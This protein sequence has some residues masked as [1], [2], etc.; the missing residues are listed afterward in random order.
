[1][2]TALG[3]V[4]F[5][6]LGCPKNLIDSE[7][8]LG[9]LASEGFTITPQYEGADVVVI[10]TCGFLDASRRE[11]LETISRMLSL[12]EK[13]EV[14]RVVV[15]GCMVGNYREMLEK[16]VPG[17]DALVSVNDRSQVTS[18]LR[19]LRQ[20]GELTRKAV[21]SDP[22]A[23]GTIYDDRGRL[24]LTPRHYAYLRISEGC[25]HTCSFCVIPSIRGKYRSKPRERIVQEARELVADGARELIVV[26]QD[27]T[28][29]GLDT[30][31]RKSLH[32]LLAEIARI[33]ELRWLRL[34]YAYP[35][36]VT[37][38][39]IDLLSREPKLLGYIDMPLQHISTPVLSRM[40]RGS[41]RESSL[42]LIERMRARVPHLTLRSTFIVG[43]PGETE[44]QFE[45]LCD[46]LKQGYIDRVGVFPYSD[47][48]QAES[49]ALDGKIHEPEIKRRHARVM[50]IAQQALFTRNE[51]LV[52]TTLDCVVE[53]KSQDPKYPSEARSTMDAP[54]IDCTVRLKGDHAPG[55]F[56]RAR[57]VRSLGFDL[58]AEPS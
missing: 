15:A 49:F 1:M 2:K 51:R 30:E 25:N 23:Q 20:S 45:E 34:M 44:A 5:V 32:E 57:V 7:T 3:T 52:G 17:A 41:T 33:P 27:S 38:D 31:N 14:K 12:K 18:V 48:P 36:Q 35:T 50:E 24:R 47:E 28:Y 13:G 21:I 46:F 29:Y 16:E 4:A 26:A 42:R 6:S 55:T 53:N 40:K 37:D 22:D 9:G 43:F 8:M 56:L 54:E 58:L 39:L 11:S 10:N 19:E